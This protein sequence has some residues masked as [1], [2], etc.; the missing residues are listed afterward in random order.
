VCVCVCLCVCIFVCLFVC[1]C[2]VCFLCVCFVCV[3]HKT[4]FCVYFVF[5]FSASLVGSHGFGPKHKPSD[6][7]N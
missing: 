6:T 7:N 1:V 4:N 2:C 3:I 5:Y